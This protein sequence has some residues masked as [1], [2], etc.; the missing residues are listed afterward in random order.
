MAVSTVALAEFLLGERVM[1][2]SSNVLAI[3]YSALNGKLFVEFIPK[4]PGGKSGRRRPGAVYYVGPYRYMTL[5]PN[6]AA[7]MFA[8]GSH[9]KWVWDHLRVRGSATAHQKAYMKEKLPLPKSDAQKR[10]V[11][12]QL[13]GVFGAIA[14]QLYP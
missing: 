12:K 4:P 6:E 7:S 5:T 13:G 2:S 10:A 1:V 14:Q 3:T 11:A 8:A 9:G